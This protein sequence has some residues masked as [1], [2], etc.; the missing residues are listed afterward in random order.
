MS[1]GL[2]FFIFMKNVEANVK[3]NIVNLPNNVTVTTKSAGFKRHMNVYIYAYERISSTSTANTLVE[4]GKT[5][6]SI[7]RCRG[8]NARKEQTPITCDFMAGNLD[9][10][11]YYVKMDSFQWDFYEL[12]NMCTL[13]PFIC[14]HGSVCIPNFDNNTYHCDWCF[15]PYYGK[16]CN[17]TDGVISNVPI[18]TDILS[19][20]KLSCRTLKRHFGPLIH[21]GI[22]EIHPWRD[23][24]KIKVECSSDGATL[25]MDL[26]SQQNGDN[27]TTLT[28]LDDLVRNQRVT[29]SVLNMFYKLTRFEQLEFGCR[30]NASVWKF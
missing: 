24:R 18:P 20:K 22:Y 14:E 9:T 28:T 1:L 7:P 4:C 6:I 23:R 2:L 21:Y 25:I 26:K 19:G 17:L 16:H 8:F 27:F 10:I 13:N 15:P 5:C 29:T 30:R 3:T 11:H 12:E